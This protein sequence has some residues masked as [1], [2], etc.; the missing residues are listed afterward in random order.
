MGPHDR[1]ITRTAVLSAL[2]FSIAASVAHT[3]PLP[4]GHSALR[5]H[6]SCSDG[7]GEELLPSWAGSL[8]TGHSGLKLTGEV[9]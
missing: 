3:Q 7:D 5:V 9:I 2:A 4:H 8:G 1:L 6:F